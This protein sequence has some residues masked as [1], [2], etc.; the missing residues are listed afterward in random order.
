MVKTLQGR[1]PVTSER[2][3]DSLNNRIDAALRRD[4]PS[5]WLSGNHRL[6]GDNWRLELQRTQQMLDSRIDELQGLRDEVAAML[7]DGGDQ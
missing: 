6:G 1:A 4:P 3:V 5:V 7:P 2:D